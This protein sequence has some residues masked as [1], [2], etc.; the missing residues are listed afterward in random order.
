[1]NSQ[2]APAPAAPSNSGSH[3]RRV[4][5]EQVKLVYRYLPALLIVN[6]VVGAAVVLGLWEMVP[7]AALVIWIAAV[8]LMLAVRGGLYGFYRYRASDPPSGRWALAFVFGT[9]LSGAIWGAAGVFLLFT[10]SL[11]HQ[12]FVLFVLMGM[13]IG[14]I[15]SLSA[16]MP[17]FYAFLPLVFL[18]GG[19]VLLLADDSIHVALGVMTVAFLVGLGLFARATNRALGRSLSLGFENTE[20]VRQ[21]SQQRDE[22][23][24][25]NIAKSKFLAAASH[26]LRQPLHALTL[27]ASALDER[28]KYPEVSRLVANVNASVK[29]MELLFNA[30]LDISRL[31]AGVLHPEIRHFRLEETIRRLVNDYA[32]EAAQ[33]GLLLQWT[34]CELTVESD[35]TLL[36]RILRN[37]VSNAIRY[38]DRGEIRIRSVPDGDRVRIEV[39][40]TGI[41]IP[42]DQ[43]RAIF[44][45]FYQ[46]GNPER[47]RTKGLGLGLAIV[48]R[49]A[50]LLGHQIEVEST[51]GRG[52]C[53][54]VVVPHGDA[55]RIAADDRPEADSVLNDL[56][57]LRIMVVDDEAG[58][59]EGMQALLQQWG[60]EVALA[61]SEEEAVAAT[62]S[63]RQV[64]DAIIADYRLRD[65]QTGVMVIERLQRELNAT[66]PALIVTGD[67]A[68]ERLREAGISGYQLLHKPVQPAMLRA[69]L[70]NVRRRRGQAC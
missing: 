15:A 56:V 31:D 44:S 57:G 5:D 70:R 26:D 21:L 36:E 1:L 24:R 37:F 34:P 54:A 35:P 60:C 65:A 4:R 51:P 7:H 10:E 46:L 16:Y 50:R 53:F 30:L 8:T 64:P 49:V 58:I 25:A 67:T 17:A 45:E 61:G 13:G 6:A 18:P 42:P 62:R 59:R 41:G 69:F 20:L 33:K 23:E 27:F 29:A 68:T 32:P 47:D 2:S 63:A 28:I 11:E 52:S 9:G 19:I 40:D 55:A 3:T 48:D 38:T 14:A 22:A 66:I 43:R 39:A 12:L